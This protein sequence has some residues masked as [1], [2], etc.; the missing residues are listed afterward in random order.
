MAY[1]QFGSGTLLEQWV[2]RGA[3]GYAAKHP[4]QRVE[5]V[6]IV[7]SEN[8]YFT[9]NELLMS[10]PRT[11][12]DVVFEDTFILLS[13]VGA[14]YLR[15]LD[16]YVNQWEDWGKVIPA[17]KKAVTGEDGH[18]YGVPVSTDTRAIWYN[19]E[20]F[21][22]A[23]LPANFAPKTWQEI[24]DAARTLKQKLPDV[25]PL[26]LFSGKPQGEK[27][28]MQ[29]FE[30][31]LYGTGSS[32]YNKETRKW[33]LGSQGFVDALSFVKTI[34]QQELTLPLAQNLDPNISETI[35]TRL[36]P[37]GKLAMIVDGSW[38]SQNW[39][40]NAPKPWPEWAKT[41]AL[42]K[43][44]TQHGQGKGW[45]TLS[46]GWCWTIPHNSHSP[47]R[48]FEMIKALCT[49]ESL[50]KRSIED[51]NITV[52]SDVAADKKYQTYSP[53]VAFFTSLVPGADY[54]PALP[55]YPEVSSAIQQA[56][57]QVM[58]GTM[59]PQQATDAYDK[60]VIEIVGADHSKRS[61]R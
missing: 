25:T 19:R 38:I 2:D 31:L 7:A 18:I 13:D 23:G 47:D 60:T 57:E 50:V 46:G 1:Q 49:T 26:F 10:S 20:L 52:R 24:L 3:R 35:Y 4:D 22:R 32:L 56:M 39:D 6:P 48:A 33:V 41:M 15:P 30:M 12:P 27:A 42:A 51:N 29:G 17:S 53:K 16:E 54:R 61:Q 40:A 58:T 5:R 14:G 21:Q 34:F 36:I 11:S 45:V 37:E 28:S 59:T 43:M 44:P 9:K 8:D 55:V